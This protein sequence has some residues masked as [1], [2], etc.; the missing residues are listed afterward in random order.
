MGVMTVPTFV[1][2][3]AE[4]EAEVVTE[5]TQGDP[6]VRTLLMLSFDSE[7]EPWIALCEYEGDGIGREPRSTVAFPAMVWTMLTGSLAEYL[8]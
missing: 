3:G 4:V 7:E 6:A 5:V 2:N 1:V 8:E